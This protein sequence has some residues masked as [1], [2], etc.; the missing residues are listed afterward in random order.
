MSVCRCK[1]PKG[2]GSCPDDHMAICRNDGYQ[3]NTECIP[4][5]V[6]QKDRY[7]YSGLIWE[8]AIARIV[9]ANYDP[10]TDYP[11]P[12]DRGILSLLRNSNLDNKILYEAIISGVLRGIGRQI[13]RPNDFRVA[14]SL[15]EILESVRRF[16]TQDSSHAD[17]YDDIVTSQSRLGACLQ[18]AD[19]SS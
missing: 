13:E 4:P 6:L 14:M 11:P 10:F 3:C 7:F 19:P 5:P 12:K 9:N 1:D 17:G 2:T 15:E 16:L 8:W 18:G